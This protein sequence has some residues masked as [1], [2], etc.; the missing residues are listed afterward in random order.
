MSDVTVSFG[1]VDEGVARAARRLAGDLATTE[2]AQG[3]LNNATRLTGKAFEKLSEG[4]AGPLGKFVKYGAAGV[5]IAGVAAA[6]RAAANASEAY[7]KVDKN[8]QL[9]LDVTTAKAEDFWAKIGKQLGTAVSHPWTST[10]AAISDAMG[11]DPELQSK[12]SEL[13]MKDARLRQD[14]AMAR[15]SDE[16]AFILQLAEEDAAYL[17][18]RMNLEALRRAGSIS[19]PQFQEQA[20]IESESHGIRTD[21][22]MQ[23]QNARDVQAMREKKAL[24]T[25]ANDAGNEQ[26]QR[27]YEMQKVDREALDNATAEAHIAELHA[28]G[29]D[30]QAQKEQ[31]ALDTARKRLDIAGRLGATDA[32]RQRALDALNASEAA[33]IRALGMPDDSST[34]SP[35]S[36]DLSPGLVSSALR[37]QVFGGGGSS[38]QNDV[39]KKLE[40]TNKTLEEI[41]K[42]IDILVRENSGF[43]LA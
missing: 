1:S 24:E 19:L 14:M 18:I 29:L 41:R 7:A 26:M 38:S 9:S 35:A 25:A 20:R 12:R 3:K 4:A 32:E 28:R 5:A 40:K 31:I 39:P 2:R 17:K 13:M 15:T 34:R 27:A 37:G 33:Q 11:S 22:L 16:A 23:A 42:G 43:A 8:T 36:R 6:W 10:K 21:K 30:L